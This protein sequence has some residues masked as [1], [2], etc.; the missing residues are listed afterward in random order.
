M[1][2]RVS[3]FLWKRNIKMVARVT[4][5]YLPGM[6]LKK[7]ALFI[8]CASLAMVSAAAAQPSG[9]N[10][11]A[12]SAFLET[13]E[14]GDLIG[15]TQSSD[16]AI[17]EWQ[18][19]DLGAGENFFF[20]QPS[21]SSIT[22]NRVLGEGASVIDGNLTA[23]G[24]I[25]IIN[26]DGVIFGANAVI[27]VNGLLATTMG[28]DDADFMAG[29]FNFQFL[30]EEGA[31]V[32]NRGDISIGEAGI[33]AF[34][35]PNVSNEG[36]IAARLGKVTL[37]TGDRF[38]L[39]F[40]GDGLVVFSPD[41]TSGEA[42][43]SVNIT[44]AINA[45]GGAIYLT[46]TDALEYVETVINVEA[47]LVARSATLEGGKIILTGA[48]STTVTVDATLD[49]SGGDGGEISITGN[50]IVVTENAALL[51]DGFEAEFIGVTWTFQNAGF[52]GADTGTPLN[53][54]FIYN[55]DTEIFSNIMVASGSGATLPGANY[56]AT[57]PDMAPNLIDFL[58]SAS[59]DIDGA[60]RLRLGFDNPLTNEGG[61]LNIAFGAEWECLGN[62][63]AF[64][65]FEAAEGQPAFA[66]GLI[67]STS[68]VGTPI[69]I[70]GSQNGGQ[71]TVS[72][73]SL[74]SFAGLASVEP[75]ESAGT[76]GDIV[77]ASDGVLDF[78]GE[79]RIGMAPREGTLMLI[80]APPEIP[81]DPE[82]PP[83]PPGEMEDEE[84]INEAVETSLSEIAATTTNAD[85][86][87]GDNAGNTSGT[88]EDSDESEQGSGATTLFE[89]QPIFEDD[90]NGD[91]GDNERQLLCL[92]GVAE[93][94]CASQ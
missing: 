49:A 36:S 5:T 81:E 7:A 85:G 14:G 24:N 32:I 51:A 8:G 1:T 90:A 89:D 93:A 21:G 57:G 35:A 55:A 42:T 12:G 10:V 50:E 60:F 23:N 16:S 26:G 2:I 17:I 45:E 39:D 46:A 54:S 78:T 76:G 41:I 59:P 75:G 94:A 18:S 25:F 64:P 22:L 27:D 91:G 47:D 3:S 83:M 30:G 77:I 40:F 68:I 80:G 62:L 74:T 70:A 4:K 28:I 82:E 92:L 9:G 31:S 63:C 34:V 53:G 38:T 88:T 43:G 48:D 84:E 11:V 72:S 67:G 44:G 79:T 19:F 73:T 15:V 37:A 86:G 71:I 33:V 65:G 66:R 6:Q 56:I 69:P 13:I 52:G 20:N 58:S 29:D 87:G 61:A